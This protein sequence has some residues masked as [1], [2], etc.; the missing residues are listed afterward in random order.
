VQAERKTALLTEMEN[1]LKTQD[2]P[3][4]FGNGK[5]FDEYTPTHNPGFYERYLKGDPTAK[6][7][8]VSP[9]DFE[10]QPVNP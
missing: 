2:D 3:R 1:K 6:A 5:V 8:W 7:G 10:K 9:T 4:M